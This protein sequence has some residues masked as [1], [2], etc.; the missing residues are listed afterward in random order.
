[1][2]QA[3]TNVRMEVITKQLNSEELTALREA[4]QTDVQN[5]VRNAV[6]E[7]GSKKG[8]PTRNIT[9]MR[10]VLTRKSEGRFKARLVV[11]RSTGPHL[12]HLRRVSPTASRQARSVFFGLGAS[13]HM[14]VHKGDVT[15]AFLHG[16]DTE[17]ECGVLAESLEEL[18]E[19]L[20]LQPWE[21]VRLGR[22]CADLP[23][24]REHGG[25]RS[26]KLWLVSA[27]LPL[28]WNLF[29]GHAGAKTD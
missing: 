1:M 25:R 16:S 3:A 10:W 12:G 29:F 17:P 2:A 9:R 6:A 28:L 24:R 4:K 7:A 14:H 22:P 23:T 13:A 19:A 27:G 20:K 15:A 5:W 18:S 21:C 11:Q 26:V 8:V